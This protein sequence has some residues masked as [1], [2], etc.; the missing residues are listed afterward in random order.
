MPRKPKPKGRHPHRKLNAVRIKSLKT[1]PY[2][3]GNG[4]YLFVEPSGAKRWVLRTIVWTAARA[5]R[6]DLG[7]GSA[8][9]VSLANARTEAAELRLAARKKVDI[10]AARRAERRIV[11]T[12]E[13][14]VKEVHKQ[15][16]A[17]FRNPKHR[18]QWL[19]SLEADIFPVFGSR[20]ISAIDTG[21]VLKALTPIWTTKPEAPR[22]L[23]QRI[24]VV[25]DWAKAS[26]FRAGDNPVGGITKVLPKV[27]PAAAHHAALA[28]AKVPTFVHT[29]RDA[30]AS[31]S[32]KFAFEFMILTAARSGE[33][34]GARWD[35]IDRSAKTWT[36]PAERIKVW[37]EHR[38][39]L[40]ARCVE[41]LDEAEKLA[42]GGGFW[43]PSRSPKAPLSNTVLLMLLR[44]LKR[45]DITAH[46][47]RSAFRD[48]AAE[49][50]N[51]PRAVCEAKLAHV[52]KDKTEAA[53][54]RSD[55]F[56]QRRKL[57]DSLTRFATT[58]PAKVVPLHG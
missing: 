40:T 19:V 17:A 46:G 26:G 37:R 39:P 43:F 18:A 42:D 27:R 44:R 55:L 32:A 15:H 11:P 21:D 6:Y 52:V 34:I 8:Q 45:T 36:I 33:V 31:D 51:M 49:R 13:A 23:K 1:G 5:K 20:P 30:N 50:T 4:L 47:F 12:F 41:L 57:M 38:V 24:K 16:G 28:Y 54:F 9:L 14:A 56:D 22:R 7:L 2:A 25:M 35:E 3:D 58:R 10:V 29:L 53:Y 48:W